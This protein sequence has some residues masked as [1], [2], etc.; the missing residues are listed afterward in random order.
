MRLSERTRQLAQSEIRA[1]SQKINAVNGINL[2]QGICDMPTPDPI[3]AAAKR[4]IDEDRSIYSHYAGAANLRSAI[5]EKVRSYNRIPVESIDQIVVSAGST[6]AF[7]TALLTLLNPGDGAIL[8]EPFY[9]YHRHLLQIF[10]FEPQ[11]VTLESPEWEV[12]WQALEDTINPGTRAIVVT[13]P[14]NPNGKVWSRAELERLLD[15]AQ[16]RDL[17]IIA[18]EIYE[19]MLYDG[20]EHVSVASLPGGFDRTITLSGFSKTY[21]MTGWRLGY[22]TGPTDALDNMGLI[23]DLMY[24]CAP[25]PLQHGVAAAFEMPDRYFSEMASDY[26]SRRTLMCSTLEKIGFDV[27][28]PQGAYYVLA[29]FEPRSS[30]PRFSDDATAAATLV[31]TAGIGTVRGASFFSDPVDG[32][33]LLR[34]CFAKDIPVLQEACDRLLRAFGTDGS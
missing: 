31:D 22:A 30:D 12:P 10:G 16:R 7:A 11:Y 33:Y 34:F 20:R 19:Y 18:D 1:I 23:N 8:F 17:T 9:G 6:G 28:W 2:G 15:I 24:I 25:T 27:V 3:K 26:D 5:L 21:N 13:T 32:R 14:G 29:S 4:A